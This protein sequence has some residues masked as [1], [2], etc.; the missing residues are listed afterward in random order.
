MN[1]NLIPI[2][3]EG[4]IQIE[5]NFLTEANQKITERIKQLEE[6]L[7][8]VLIPEIIEKEKGE[9][10]SLSPITD[11]GKTLRAITEDILKNEAKIWEIYKR[12]VL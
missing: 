4:E 11:L 12:I 6:K 3:K 5:I 10:K 1:E 8:P 9:P 2:K 7:K